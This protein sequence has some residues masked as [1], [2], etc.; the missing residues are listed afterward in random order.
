[1]HTTLASNVL[2]GAKT[3]KNDPQRPQSKQVESKEQRDNKNC[4]KE[5]DSSN[6]G[7]DTTTQNQITANNTV[8]TLNSLEAQSQSN[9]AEL[10]TSKMLPQEGNNSA[11]MMTQ[12]DEEGAS[13]MHHGGGG[14]AQQ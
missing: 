4:N 7:G 3:V 10:F 8:T 11:Q 1:M 5:V 12:A 14:G 13:F 6:F 9:S 2:L